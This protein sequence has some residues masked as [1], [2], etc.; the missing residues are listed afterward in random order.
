MD[1][2]ER[3]AALAEVERAN[4]IARRAAELSRELDTVEYRLGYL[5]ALLLTLTI[6]AR[7]GCDGRWPVGRR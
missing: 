6:Y 2:G 4:L 1:V 5:E 3:A 7:D